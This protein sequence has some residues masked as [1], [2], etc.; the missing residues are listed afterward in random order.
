V[1]NPANAVS[2]R[3]ENPVGRSITIQIAS[4]TVADAQALVQTIRARQES[5]GS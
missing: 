5:R 2:A 4:G 1:G 3:K